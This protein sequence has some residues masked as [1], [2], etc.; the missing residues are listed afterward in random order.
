VARAARSLWRVL[1]ET[2]Y[3]P[4]LTHGSLVVLTV[5]LF[6]LLLRAPLWVAFV[7]CAILQHRIGVLLHEYIHGIPFSRYRSN[8]RVLVFFDGLLLTYGF[9]ELFRGT[10]L[11]HHRWLNTERDFG[12][13]CRPQE[14]TAAIR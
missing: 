9:G 7:P 4:L 5:L 14:Q 12:V 3:A 13:R 10:H 6:V 1:V 8:L 11:A 2:R